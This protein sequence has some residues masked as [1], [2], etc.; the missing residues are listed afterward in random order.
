MHL[1]AIGHEG[2]DRTEVAHDSVKIINV[3]VSGKSEHGL[4]S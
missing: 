4:S 1:T 2:A 3:L